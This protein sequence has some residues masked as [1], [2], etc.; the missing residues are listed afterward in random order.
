[1][2]LPCFFPVVN[3]E[4]R[5]LFCPFYFG[6]SSTLSHLGSSSRPRKTLILPPLRDHFPDTGGPPTLCPTGLIRG[7]LFFPFLPLPTL[8]SDFFTLTAQ[9][10]R[11]VGGTRQGVRLTFP[12]LPSF[13]FRAVRPEFHFF[14]PHAVVPRAASAMLCGVAHSSSFFL[15]R[16]K[17][18][19]FPTPPSPPQ[20]FFTPGPET[21]Q[22]CL[23][24][25]VFPLWQPSI[26][27]SLD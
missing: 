26:N 22:P 23:S 10:L 20:L 3:P 8:S 11:C 19:S 7:R 24:C 12:P 5:P 15:Y 16:E 1:M 13:F 27:G 18:R 21:L 25:F 2:L 17:S 6:F 14:P 9:K 4:R